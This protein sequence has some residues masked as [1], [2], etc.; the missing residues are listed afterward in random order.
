MSFNNLALLFC[1]ISYINELINPRKLKRGDKDNKS[2]KN[3]AIES[4]EGKAEQKMAKLDDVSE[5]K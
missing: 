1:L 2:T 4:P 5:E 3:K